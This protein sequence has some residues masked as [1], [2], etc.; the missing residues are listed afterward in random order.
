MILDRWVDWLSNQI[1]SFLE[2]RSNK[3]FSIGK[4]FRG[5]SP[6]ALI[7]ARMLLEH[8]KHTLDTVEQVHSVGLTQKAFPKGY[9]KSRDEIK[10]QYAI[11]SAALIDVVRKLGGDAEAQQF[12]Q[13]L[14]P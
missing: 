9:S 11:P 7:E 2:A 1:E 13:E 4:I 12:C 8:I 10:L 3:G 6:R 14:L 5:E